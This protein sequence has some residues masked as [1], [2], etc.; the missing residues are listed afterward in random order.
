[1]TRERQNLLDPKVY[2]TLPEQSF[3][4]I[5]FSKVVRSVTRETQDLDQTTQNNITAFKT[6]KHQMGSALG[7]WGDPRQCF[8]LT[9]QYSHLSKHS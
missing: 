8:E 9:K 6:H 5:N 1:M 4:D 7:D 2:K 3:Q